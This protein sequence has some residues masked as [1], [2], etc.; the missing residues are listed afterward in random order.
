M[1]VIL[2]TVFSSLGSFYMKV[3]SENITLNIKTVVRNMPLVV[4]VTL[5]TVSAA[6]GVI[7]YRGGELTVLV[8]LAS[9]NYI[10]ASLLA[11]RYLGEKMNGWKWLGIA[12]IMIGITLIGL[13]DV[14]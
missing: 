9:L 1:L 14:I 12:G 7:A 8:P 4:A 10:W 2:S 13:G 3:A 6:I 5:H 11:I